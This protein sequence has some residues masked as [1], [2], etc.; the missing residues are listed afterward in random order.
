[1][2]RALPRGRIPCFTRLARETTMKQQTS[3]RRLFRAALAASL[4][5]CTACTGSER[6]HK[7]PSGL[8]GVWSGRALLGTKWAPRD[9][10]LPLEI[11]I[12]D[13][14]RVEG[15]L[16]GATLRNSHIASNRGAVGRALDLATE[17]ILRGEIEGEVAAGEPKRS[18]FVRAPF[19]VVE[20]PGE[21][22]LLWGSVTTWEHAS[23]GKNEI[24]GA[25]DLE[26]RRK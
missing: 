10:P 25:H 7:T 18:K 22:T 11:E 3:T 9:Q 15:T 6:L 19:N 5:L 13:D 23:G 16:G 17:Y 21:T 8:E 24:V 14:G 2:Q 12:F 1:M 4:A 20:R 26:L